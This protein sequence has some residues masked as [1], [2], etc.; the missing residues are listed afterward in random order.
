MKIYLV[1]DCINSD[2]LIIKAGQ[3]ISANESFHL[4][5]RDDDGIEDKI[6]DEINSLIYPFSVNQSLNSH[7][8]IGN[9]AKTLLAYVASTLG[10]QLSY[11]RAPFRQV[12]W[13]LQRKEKSGWNT[14]ASLSEDARVTFC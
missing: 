11:Q 9:P 3:T 4:F 1:F 10:Q 7:V 2:T 14:T 12:L 13:L 5:K 8:S 6:T